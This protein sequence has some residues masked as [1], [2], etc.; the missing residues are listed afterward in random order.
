MSA[1][2]VDVLG[3]SHQERVSPGDISTGPARQRRFI[4]RINKDRHSQSE[5]GMLMCVC[6]QMGIM[7]LGLFELYDFKQ[8]LANE[9]SASQYGVAFLI[10]SNS[11]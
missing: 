5:E 11:I 7:L 8:L 3:I 6:I 10:Y 2:G 4:I 1:E 9:L